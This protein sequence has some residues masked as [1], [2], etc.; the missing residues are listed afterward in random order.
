[1]PLTSRS[2]PPLLVSASIRGPC[3]LGACGPCR[4]ALVRPSA[5]ESELRMPVG[6]TCETCAH[7]KRREIDAALRS[8]ARLTQLAR[9]F[10][11]S[12]SSLL[13]H[14]KKHLDAL[15]A[16]STTPSRRVDTSEFDA[17]AKAQK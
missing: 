10:G 6:R 3:P 16:V 15:P 9:K 1:M 17:W 11:P 5:R 13:R 2:G 7:A 12:E 4:A 8:G 14:R